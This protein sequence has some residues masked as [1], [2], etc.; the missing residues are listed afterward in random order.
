MFEFLTRF[1]STQLCV[2]ECESVYMGRELIKTLIYF[3]SELIALVEW[4]VN[5]KSNNE[6]AFFFKFEEGVY[7]HE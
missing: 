4:E 7:Q 2:D 3:P 5:R 6:K 1:A